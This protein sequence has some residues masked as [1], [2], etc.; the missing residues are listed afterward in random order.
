MFILPLYDPITLYPVRRTYRSVRRLWLLSVFLDVEP[1][2][3]YPSPNTHWSQ[4]LG[5][6]ILF[7]KLVI[8][9]VVS[10]SLTDDVRSVILCLTPFYK[11]EKP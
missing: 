10:K 1:P 9:K 11:N 3:G 8:K 7:F 6:S 4:L 2:S 5:P